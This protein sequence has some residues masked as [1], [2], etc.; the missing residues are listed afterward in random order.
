MNDAARKRAQRAEERRRQMAEM[1]AAIAA[2]DIDVS[3]T[4][5]GMTSMPSS[6]RD[7][8]T[9]AFAGGRSNERGTGGPAPSSEYMLECS[10]LVL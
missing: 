8:A 6:S 9:E 3:G 4:N 2:L 5:R 7:D 1:D 10:L